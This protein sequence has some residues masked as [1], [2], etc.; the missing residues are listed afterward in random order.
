MN[1]PLCG[2]EDSSEDWYRTHFRCGT[3]I[4][5]FNSVRTKGV[6]CLERQLS[7]AQHTQAQTTQVT[8]SSTGA[9][10]TE[11]Q[12]RYCGLVYTRK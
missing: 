12:A 3:T 10:Q 6:L 4:D 9:V 8:T 7:R 2:E 5:Q 1:C 11:Q